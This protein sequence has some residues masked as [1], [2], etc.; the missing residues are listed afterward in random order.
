MTELEQKYWQ[1]KDFLDEFYAEAQQE[2]LEE[3]TTQLLADLYYFVAQNGLD[4]EHI[5]DV[6]ELEALP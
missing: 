4:K 1:I 2:D 6:A 5:K 3:A